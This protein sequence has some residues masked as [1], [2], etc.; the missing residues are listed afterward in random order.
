MKIEGA[1]DEISSL[2]AEFN[3]LLNEE[4]GD[5]FLQ[6]Q[7]ILLEC[8]RRFPVHVPGVETLVKNDKLQLYYAS[9]TGQATDQVKIIANVTGD[10]ITH[11]DISIRLHKQST[12]S[13]RFAVQNDGPW[14]LNQIQDASNHLMAA[15]GIL[16]YPPLRF[17]DGAKKFDFISAEEIVQIIN[18]VMTSLH[19]GRNSLIIPK[20][21]TIDELQ[22]SRNMKSIQP[23]LP[24]DL[25]ISFY[26]QSHKMICAVYYMQK[27]QQGQTK[28]DIYQAETSIPWLSE[29]LVLFTVALQCCQQ[30]KDKVSV[31]TQYRDMQ[32]TPAEPEYD[33]LEHD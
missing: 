6:L 14:K 11:A 15:L 7:N 24:N 3:W 13:Q 8:S 2:Q 5:I 16:K 33:D 20:K 19:R 28:F 29:V 9:G 21:R 18:N 1:S 17:V 4:V 32:K 27:D 30:L 25:A 22:S 26:V 31:F 23:P 12:Q 10:N